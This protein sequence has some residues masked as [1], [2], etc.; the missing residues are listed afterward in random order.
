MKTIIKNIILAATSAAV[1]SACN[2]KLDIIP[3]G[4]PTTGNFW[5]TDKD[6]ISGA[7]AMYDQFDDENFYGRGYWWFINASDDQIVG[8]VK[9]EGDNIKN[10]NRNFIGG[11]YTESQ[12]KL[13]YIVIKRANDVILHVPSINMDASLKNRVLGE[14]YFLSGLMYFQ[15]AYTY[16]GVPIV[17]R[18]NLLND[19]PMVAHTRQLPWHFSAKCSFTKRTMPMQRN[20]PILL[21]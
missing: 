13:R 16:G 6:A 8:R 21:F 1:L 20:M 5:T 11:S 9:A 4:S 15:L 18:S 19:K 14:A 3:E 7:N 10:F 17:D 12:W 2:K